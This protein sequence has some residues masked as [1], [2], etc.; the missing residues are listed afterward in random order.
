MQQTFDT[1]LTKD[2]EYIIDLSPQD[3]DLVTPLSIVFK[4]SDGKGVN[5][6]WT[7][8]DGEQKNLKVSTAQKLKQL[9]N[10]NQY[11]IMLLKY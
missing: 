5:V 2:Q 4:L 6:I 1:A 8:I 10:S 11:E 7:E 9:Q 3:S